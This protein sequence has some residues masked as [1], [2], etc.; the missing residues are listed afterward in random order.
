MNQQIKIQHLLWR[1]GF[2]L[3]LSEL[4]EWTRLNTSQAVDKLFQESADYQEIILPNYPIPNLKELPKMPKEQRRELLNDIQRLI[5]N[6]NLKWLAQ[7]VNSKAQLR[8]KMAFF[9][10]GHFACETKNVFHAQKQINTIRKDALGKLGD[11][12]LTIAKDPAMLRFLNNQQN[13]KAHPNENFARELLELFTLG[14]GNYTEQDI[15][16]AARAFT[17][18]GFVGDE[19]V[20]RKSQHDFDKKTFMGKTGNFGGEDI[21]QIVLENRQ[22]ARFITAKIYRFLVNEVPD[23]QLVNELAEKFYQS[24]YDIAV[25]LRQIFTSEWFYADQNVG[26]KIKSPIE[27]IVGLQRQFNLKFTQ[28]NSQLFLQ[29]VLGQMLLY[30]PNVAGWPGGRSWIDSSS[31]LFRLRL[32]EAIY[33]FSEVDTEAKE[34]DDMQKMGV[35]AE[36]VRKFEAEFDWQALLRYCPST[37]AQETIFAQLSAYFLQ[38][39]PLISPD[40]VAKYKQ[41]NSSEEAIK[42]LAIALASTPE[43]QVC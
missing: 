33:R 8:E 4:P 35:F 16:E 28:E 13:R 3:K 1:G 6:L 37:Y 5:R 12:L 18:W 20:F 42:L 25:L 7:M 32:P 41:T 38:K 17:G 23:T 2:G 11:L 15:K 29:K 24:N 39:K 43:Y 30:P 22:T 27:L 10:H 34:E 14:R 36:R 26:A 40:L 9:W 31:L 21:I 19:F